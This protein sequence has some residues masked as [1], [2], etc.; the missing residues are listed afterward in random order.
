MS[1]IGKKIINIPDSVSIDINT[2][3]VKIKG[4]KGEIAIPV[5]LDLKISQDNQTVKIERPSDSRNHKSL[6]GTTRQLIANGVTGVS[7]GFTKELEIIGV[8]F[9]LKI[10]ANL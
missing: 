1:R 3:L 10:R 5:H 8:D 9:Q 7:E 2:G 4:P 6:H